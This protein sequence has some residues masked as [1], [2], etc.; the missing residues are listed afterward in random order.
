MAACTCGGTR[1]RAVRLAEPFRIGQPARCLAAHILCIPPR[2][3]PDRSSGRF[4]LHRRYK[5]RA[6]ALSKDLE[7]RHDSILEKRVELECF[8]V[9]QHREA[10]A[11]PQREEQLA[12]MLASQVTPPPLTPARALSPPP[13]VYNS[14]PPAPPFPFGPRRRSRPTLACPP[15]PNV[16]TPVF[17]PCEQEAREDELQSRYAELL[18]T[19]ETLLQQ[20]RAR[21]AQS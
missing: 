15:V 1:P 2:P 11:G 16:L 12:A 9:L 13:L 10:L 20:T 4:L 7:R 21:A 14:R 5:K 6:S 19:R 17:T 8:R 18:R 3:S